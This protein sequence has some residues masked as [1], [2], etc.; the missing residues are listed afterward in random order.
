MPRTY[1]PEVPAD[2]RAAWDRGGCTLPAPPLV[3]Q[4]VLRDVARSHRLRFFVET[5]TYLGDTVAALAGEFEALVT[6]EL[7]P[8]LHERA[9]QR[10][11]GVD[12]VVCLRGDSGSLLPQIMER[13][14]APTL[15]WLDAH[16]SG[17]GT[18]RGEIDTPILAELRTI[19]RH[20]SRGHVVLVDDAR[21][22]GMD[23][24]YPT[25]RQVWDLV[26]A[27]RPDYAVDVGV[28]MVRVTP[29]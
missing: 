9:R 1:L 20:P 2:V 15:F 12:R 19:L 11:A 25:V 18:A 5:G 3:K 6:I 17:P 13:V 4:A 21:L 29:A 26:R 7:D 27:E 8:G 16:Y 14:A 28:D 24:A 22:F 23:P 10:F